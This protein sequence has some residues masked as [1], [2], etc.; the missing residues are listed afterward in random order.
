MDNPKIKKVVEVGY[1]NWNIASRIHFTKDKNYYGFEDAD[2]LRS[3]ESN[4]KFS[5]FL[6]VDEFTESGDLLIVK[7]LNWPNTKIEKF[8]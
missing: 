3:D 4:K 6:G 5:L 1:G 7:D 8:L 2:K